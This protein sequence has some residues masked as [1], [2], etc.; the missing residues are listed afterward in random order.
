MS[1]GKILV[2]GGAG[3]IGSHTVVELITR[4]YEVILADNFSNSRKDVIDAIDTITGKKTTCVEI[5]LCDAA[6]TEALFINHRFDAV[7]HFAAKKLVGESVEQPLLYYRNNLQSL[8][9]VAES[10]LLS[11]CSNFVFSS[12]CT[13]YGQPDVLP[14]NENS[15]LKRAESPYGNTKKISEDILQDIAKV[16][17]LKIIALR[18]F[19][20]VGAHE[21]ALIG[22][23]PLNAPAN[24]MPVITQVAIGKRP[25]F[26][27]FGNDYNTPDG[28]CIRD[29]IHVT[30]VAIAHVVAIEKL[31]ANESALPFEVYNLGTGNG[32]SVFELIDS[33]EKVNNIKLNYTLAPRRPGDVEQVWADTSKANKMLGWKAERN[34]DQMV[35]SAW[36]WEKQLHEKEIKHV[37]Q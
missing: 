29:Y 19:N 21:S 24:L 5:D 7:I 10:A 11:G 26:N 18:Y 22:E 6:L 35:A 17:A 32:V 4:G 13:V 30:D 15:P 25:S 33:F 27:V 9:N 16:S 8:L 20:P 23:Y 31:L 28:S 14:V 36:A 37:N 2:T 34:L 3:F 12:S 1:K